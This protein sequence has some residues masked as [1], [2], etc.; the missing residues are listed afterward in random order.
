MIVVV[1][2]VIWVAALTPFLLRRFSEHQI[3]SSVSRFRSAVGLLRRAQPHLDA[4]RSAP[5]ARP[6]SGP[7]AHPR[8]RDAVRR[9]QRQIER[10]RQLLFRLAGFT[11]GAFVLGA[12]PHLHLLW[13]FGVIGVVMTGAYIFLLVQLARQ[14]A[15]LPMEAMRNVVSLHRHEGFGSPG[16]V[17]A[18]GAGGAGP[19]PFEHRPA[20]VVV[21]RP[22]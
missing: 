11:I 14:D 10:R 18:A 20:F 13:V 5:A 8:P 15:P 3:A 12:I 6:H 1:L 4:V 7:Q 2:V 22:S 16:R 21:E 17:A 9:R 19:A